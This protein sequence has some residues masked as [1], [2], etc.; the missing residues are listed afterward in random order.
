MQYLFAYGLLRGEFES[1]V[2][3][4][5][6]QYAKRQGPATLRAQL[7]DL[8]GYPGVI[9]PNTDNQRVLA[10]CL[11]SL[12]QTSSGCRSITSKVWVATIPNLLSTG[13]SLVP[14]QGITVKSCKPMSTGTTGR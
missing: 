10:S 8:G 11:K 3:D 6:Q 9:P 7:F 12:I 4:L 1:P 5:M 13:A 2:A 14:L